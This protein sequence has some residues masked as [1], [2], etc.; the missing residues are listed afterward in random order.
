[1]TARSVW[2]VAGWLFGALASFCAY[3]FFRLQ[4]T[5]HADFDVSGLLWV[6][7]NLPRLFALVVSFLFAGVALYSWVRA[8]RG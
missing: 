5:P 7:Q 1:M 6:L 4:W 3:W 8:A 2:I